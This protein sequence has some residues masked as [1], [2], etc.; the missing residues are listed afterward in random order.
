MSGPASAWTLALTALRLW[1]LDPS[2]LGGMVIR[3]RHGPVRTAFAELV[4]D[5][6]PS[7]VQDITPD[8]P[9]ETL[10][11]GVDLGATLAAGHPVHRMGALNERNRI[12]SLTSAER[13]RPGLAARLGQGLDQARGHALLAWD[14]GTEDDPAPPSALTT[15]L[16]FRVD[17]TECR[18]SDTVGLWDAPD[19]GP[20]PQENTEAVIKWLS[21]IADGL[22]VT[23]PRAVLFALKAARAH[24]RLRHTP[25]LEDED[26]AIATTL[27]LLPRATRLPQVHAEET[28]PAHPP[29]PEADPS[30]QTQA[31][32]GQSKEQEIPQDLTLD[33]IA[34]RLPANLLDQLRAQAARARMPQTASG[35]GQGQRQQGNRR[36]RPLPP[37]PGRPDGRTRVDLVAT[38][39]TAAPW[40]RLRRASAP[41][42]ME[43]RQVLVRASDLRFRRVE[44]RS[45][46]VLIFSVDASGSTALTRLAEAKGAIELLLAQA[47]ARRD[48]VALIAFRGQGAEV[49][50]PPT[51]SL[52]QAK[53]RL[54]ALPGGGGTPLADGLRS[55]F[56]L[57]RQ[58]WGRGLTPSL[59]VLTDGKANIALDG[60]PDRSKAQ[61][62]VEAWATAIRAKAI[63]SI[64]IDTANRPQA[65][66]E[67]LSQAIGG[68]Y[69]PLPRADAERLSSAIGTVL[70][71]R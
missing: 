64:V 40:Q 14:E 34:A 28:E 38:L 58:S 12:F 36:G 55:A 8:V 23:D 50:L 18:W 25:I 17:L 22:G 6:A 67:A 43:H 54:S 47:Y 59:A 15:R 53:R 49:L 60:M 45:D 32:D 71:P 5:W 61:G 10:F 63:P 24:G 66:A 68:T 29:P 11:G 57:A 48:H 9:D 37:R 3:A 4:R 13:V 27:V 33:A 41:E 1:S 31:E 35:G 46:R 20:A 44:N 52:V 7:T 19:P 65:R 56:E 16:A 30:D 21:D 70:E 39:R 69:L 42:G 62:D 2:G 26:L 51:R